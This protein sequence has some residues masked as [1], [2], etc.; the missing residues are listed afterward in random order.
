MSFSESCIFQV[1]PQKCDEFE[2]IVEEL[3]VFLGN[4]EGI[5]SYSFMKR[6]H[7]IIDMDSIREGKPPKKLTR[8]VKSVKY[9]MYLEMDDEQVHGT[10]TSEL[11]RQYDKRIS[12]C[13]IMPANKF[14]GTVI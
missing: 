5:N 10:F 11:F 7:R 2:S 1:K 8:I 6:T 3:K 4:F 13:L 14:I 9:I 12:K